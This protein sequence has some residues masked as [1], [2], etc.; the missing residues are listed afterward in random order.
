MLQWNYHIR[1]HKNNL[2]NGRRKTGP[3]KKLTR[4]IILLMSTSMQQW[5]CGRTCKFEPG[6]S[7]WY[8]ILAFRQCLF[9]SFPCHQRAPLTAHAKV[10]NAIEIIPARTHLNSYYRKN[11]IALINRLL[12][13]SQDYIN[14]MA[15]IFI[16]NESGAYNLQKV[17]EIFGLFFKEKKTIRSAKW[18]HSSMITTLK[19]PLTSRHAFPYIYQMVIV[20]YSAFPTELNRAESKSNPMSLYS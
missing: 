7:S 12:L 9:L 17:W 6:K 13:I 16:V 18:H 8:N 19:S 1:P 20:F 3:Y 10:T 5:T 15:F 11:I 2:K 14:S 4:L